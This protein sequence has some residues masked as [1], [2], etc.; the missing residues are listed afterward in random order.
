MAAFGMDSIG[1]AL[2]ACDL[3]LRP[4]TGCVGV[5][6]ALGAD[7]GGF[8]QNQPCTG[9]LAV[10]LYLQI[11]GGT[12]IKGTHAGQGCHHH[13][14]GQG[15][16]ANVESLLE[17]LGH[18]CFSHKKDRL[19]TSLSVSYGAHSAFFNAKGL[20]KIQPSHD[21][22]GV[23]LWQ[24]LSKRELKALAKPVIS[25]SISLKTLQYAR[26]QLRLMNQ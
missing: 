13:A 2:P 4:D 23:R 14:I 3:R 17:L 26:H 11:T 22:E 24:K 18:E 9:T 12:R 25:K 20:K 8:R 6:H 21:G 1:H 10:V 16:R 15:H 7:R 5:A 19:L